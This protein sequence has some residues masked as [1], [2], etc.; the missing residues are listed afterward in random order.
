MHLPKESYSE[1][2]GKC[3]HIFSMIP[4]QLGMDTQIK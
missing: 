3:A 4:P 1:Q 2:K